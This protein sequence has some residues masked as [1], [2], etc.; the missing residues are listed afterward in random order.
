MA[1]DKKAPAP[2]KWR[3]IEVILILFFLASVLG[4]LATSIENYISANELSFY[5]VSFSTFKSFFGSLTWIFKLFSITISVGAFSGVVAL[6][7]LRGQLLNEEKAKLFP[8]MKTG[9]T[10]DL[11]E[12]AVLEEDDEVK[13][14]WKKIVEHSA[15]Q[16]ESDWRVAIIEAD[17]I[18]EDLLFKLNLPGDTIGEKLK[19]V[20]PSDFLSLN[21]AWEAHKAR[22][23]IAHAG[24]D[25]SLNQ[26]EIRRIVS[27][28]EKVFKEFY[29]I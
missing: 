5:G 15:S 18:L 13:T 19:A 10:P 29:L 6:S 9:A 22:N 28:Y 3:P 1:D 17:I 2:R 14:R 21:E 7:H 23:N 20:E 4:A 16:S 8:N 26:R 24:S 11:P 27:L 25:F 12:G